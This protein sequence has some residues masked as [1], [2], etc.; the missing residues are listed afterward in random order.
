MLLLLLCSDLPQALHKVLPSCKISF[1]SFS[2]FNLWLL[3][4]PCG[5]FS[6]SLNRSRIFLKRRPYCVC[7]LKSDSFSFHRN[8]LMN[9]N[10]GEF[11]RELCE[12][13]TKK[14]VWLVMCSSLMLLKIKKRFHY[15]HN[16]HPHNF[17]FTPHSVMIL[18]Y[19]DMLKEFMPFVKN[20]ECNSSMNFIC[21]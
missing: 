7:V 1:S 18:V 5:C 15:S 12:F 21:F 13:H 4:R 20:D 19:F 17:Y 14:K 11:V 8:W 6:L 10:P 16:S 9:N 2:L 3:F